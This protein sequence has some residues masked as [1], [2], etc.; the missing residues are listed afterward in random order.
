MT[1]LAAAFDETRRI[2]TTRR[3][4]QRPEL[5]PARPAWGRPECA[6]P[7]PVLAVLLAVLAVCALATAPARGQELEWTRHEVPGPGAL[8]YD[9]ARGV[10]VLVSGDQTWE[11]DGTTWTRRMVTGPSARLD[12]AMA[13]DAARGVTVLFGGDQTWEWD[14]TSWTQRMVTGPSA[15]Y[16]HAMAYDA[17]RGVTVL[18][19]GEDI[20]SR[21]NPY[22]D[23]WE[24]DGTSWTQRM[25]TGPSARRDHAM[26]YNS[27]RAV[28]VLF[29]G[30]P[31]AGDTWE[32]DGTTWT[33]RA[34]SG[35]P[36]QYS[37][38]MAY[39]AARGVTV[40]FG[41]DQTWE[42]DG[43][44]WTQ[45]MPYAF[46]PGRNEGAAACRSGMRSDG[47]RCHAS[48]GSSEPNR[49]ASN[50]CC[51]RVTRSHWKAS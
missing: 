31:P 36:A 11:W 48:T 16:G 9:M 3:T 38:A 20:F 23:T 44:S 6:L 45:R 19:G 4:D 8:A 21:P 14:G 30:Y 49:L 50:A 13:Y 42:W 22:S 18:F 27:L 34:V 29:G 33:Q 47:T 25:V 39:D 51:R 43:T 28:T 41:G 17:A 2:L 37:P 7:L 10:T 26:A 5:T 12:H 35:P 15:R 24:W 32:W 1:L 46:F 40:L